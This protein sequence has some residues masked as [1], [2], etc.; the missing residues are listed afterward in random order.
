MPFSSISFLAVASARTLKPIRMAPEAN[1][2][3]ASPS[4]IPPTPPNTTFTSTSSLDNAIREPRNASKLPCTS[5]LITRLTQASSPV[6]ILENTS[7]S[8]EA[9]CAACLLN[10]LRSSRCLAKSLAIRSFCTTRNSSPANGVPDKPRIS[11]GAQG[12]ASLI[13]LPFSL[14]IARTRPYC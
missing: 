10:F 13:A 11:T 3:L 7:S 6:A 1:A 4:L 2:R 12:P 9:C 5:V 14:N 8:L